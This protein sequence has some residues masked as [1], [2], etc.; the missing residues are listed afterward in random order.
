MAQGYSVSPN[1][2]ST[3][4][5]TPAFNLDNGFPAYQKAP[6]LDPSIYDGR[7]V[8]GGYIKPFFGRPSAIYSWSLQL[9]QQV[10]S[11]TVLAVG[12]VGNRA[13]H[14]HSGFLTN[15]N[16][17]P[18]QY[19]AL[20][21]NLTD[22]VHG[23]TVG[24]AQ[25][26][27]GFDALWGGGAQVQR[28]LRPFPQFT[29]VAADCCL[30]NLGHSSYDGLLVS[31]Q[32]NFTNG[33]QFLASYTWSKNL[34]DADSALPFV[35]GGSNAAIAQG[36]D[37]TNLKLNKSISLQDIPHTFVISY[38]YELPFGKGKPFLNHGGILNQ[39]IGGWQVGGI[40]R[41]ESGA[42]ISFGCSV[43][44]PGWDNCVR[45]SL[46]GNPIMSPAARAHKINP[47]ANGG[48]FDP[49]SSSYFHGA[50]TGAI[51]GSDP[52]NPAFFDQ[53]LP[54][55]R[56]A[57]TYRFGTAPR[58]SSNARLDPYFNEDFSLLKTFPIHENLG[59]TFKA[60]ALNAFNRHTFTTV[61]TNVNSQTFGVASGL[62]NTPRSLQL[63]GRITF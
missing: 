47:L 36:E 22:P 14:L 17:M 5:F 50:T 42:P 32:R 48:L 40:Q 54:E 18:K 45:F 3:D 57:G 51:Y 19:F 24:V 49:N 46:T 7:A 39:V 33:L 20:G 34:T 35:T 9:Q 16:N 26:F 13:T 4:G 55:Y 25:P 12:Y 30:E 62:I 11:N 58:V 1:P 61:D 27:A 10:T 56:G 23:N 15:D 63:T 6:N 60:E 28:A 41:Y 8:N 44:I 31:L 52:T 43:G 21:N 53:N 38:L 37:P 2:V 59:F 29:Y